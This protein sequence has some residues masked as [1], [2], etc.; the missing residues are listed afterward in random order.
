MRHSLLIGAVLLSAACRQ[1]DSKQEQSEEISVITL[2]PPSGGQGTSMVVRF[3]G[4]ASAF[5]YNDT[6][7]VDFGSGISVLQLNIEDGWNA[8]ADI[9]IEP[10]M[11]N[12]A[13]EMSRIYRKGNLC[14]SS[15]LFQWYQIR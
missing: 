14:F 9:Q 15:N 13:R 10:E 2:S 1:T 8:T 11:L 6:S 7:S 3:D 5:T 4:T 12:W